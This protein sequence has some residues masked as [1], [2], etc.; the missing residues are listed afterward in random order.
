MSVPLAN[1]PDGL[2]ADHPDLDSLPPRWFDRC[3]FNLHDHKADLLLMCG[4]GVYPSSDVIDGWMILIRDGIQRNLRVS[5]HWGR[6][7]VGGVGVINYE[8]LEP[9]HWQIRLGD[10]PS[11][12]SL[13]ATWRGR[14]EPFEYAPLVFPDGHGDM[15]EFEHLVQSGAWEG[16]LT[17]DGEDIDVT[18]FYGQRDRSRGVRSVHARQGLHLWVQ[19]QFE[20]FHISLMYDEDRQGNTTLSEGVVMHA[21]GRHDRV[22]NIRHRLEIGTDLE[23]TGGALKIVTQAGEVFELNATM[24][25][26][27]GGY[28]AGAG[29]DGRHGQRVGRNHIAVETW[30]CEAVNLRDL[31][32]PITDRAAQ[33]S[34]RGEIGS[35]IFETAITRSDRYQY[36]ATLT[37]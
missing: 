9:S 16:V 5:D 26:D 21:D 1:S 34:C 27:G 24:N 17:V 6:A 14:L 4:L 3:Y 37:S 13:S 10:N 18:G 30:D 8:V 11:G 22:S 31:G 12:V 28:L 19:P 23:V 2:L 7:D 29:Y 36:R 15:T 25:S 20:D 33:F 32:T 35:G